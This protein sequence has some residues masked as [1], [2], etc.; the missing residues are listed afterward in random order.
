VLRDLADPHGHHAQRARDYHPLRSQEEHHHEG[1]EALAYAHAQ[2]QQNPAQA[3]AELVATELECGLLVSPRPREQPRGDFYLRLCDLGGRATNLCPLAATIPAGN[4]SST[5]RGAGGITGPSSAWG[6]SRPAPR[7]H[8]AW[9]GAVARGV[10]RTGISR[11]GCQAPLAAE[12][13]ACN[14]ISER[15]TDQN[16]VCLHL[17]PGDTGSH[18]A[19]PSARSR[20]SWASARAF[21]QSLA[22]LTP[23]CE[24]LGVPAGPIERF[25]HNR[26][27]HPSPHHRVAVFW[28][29]TF[30][31]IV[32]AISTAI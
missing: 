24:V 3:C 26:R 2:G 22:M 23:P 6:S 13:R 21:A 4:W 17:D 10:H 7:L 28:E 31:S 25:G 18:A 29:R 15:R 5:A 8:G 20:R 14:R 9:P 19:R 1:D 27:R 32:A 11:R 16:A 12:A 30:P